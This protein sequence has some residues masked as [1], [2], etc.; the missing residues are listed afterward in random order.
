MKLNLEMIDEVI[1]RTDCSYKDA[2]EALLETEGDILEA[3]ILLESKGKVKEKAKEKIDSVAEELTEKLK[4][5]LEKGD[6]NRITIEK[7]NKVIM[8]IPVTA[9][10]VGA[11][12]FAPAVLTSVIVALA[13]GH[14]VKII[15]E[16]G[17]VIDFKEYTDKTV[18]TVK[19]KATEVK[20][21]FQK[22][23]KEEDLEEEFTEETDVNS[24][25]DKV[26]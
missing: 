2:K 12:I 25:D 23:S 13:T 1:E 7:N 18:S 22:S 4:K 8:D 9:G 14:S 11:I 20:E 16:N 5:I 6:V 3:I 15:K 26:E 19:E 24:E 21:K 17:E 10:I